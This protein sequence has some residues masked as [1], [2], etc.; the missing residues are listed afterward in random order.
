MIIFRAIMFFKFLEY[1][2]KLVGIT[3]ADVLKN[4][5]V[6]VPLKYVSHFW[7]SLEMPLINC[8]IELKVKW[9][10]YFLGFK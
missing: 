3:A 1:K 7:R 8:K 4:A 2:I 6:T 9:A 5:T 10:K